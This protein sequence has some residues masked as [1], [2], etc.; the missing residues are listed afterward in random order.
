MRIKIEHED[1][2]Y[3]NEVIKISKW[4]IFNPQEK[5]IVKHTLNKTAFYSR[6]LPKKVSAKP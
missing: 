1:G 4:E 2:D 6:K 3:K 5:K